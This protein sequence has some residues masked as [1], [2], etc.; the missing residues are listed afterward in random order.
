MNKKCAALLLAAAGISF[1]LSA[2]NDSI[3]VTTDGKI[4]KTSKI[5][6]NAKGDLEYLTPDGKLKNRIPNGRFR[7]AQVPK[8]AEITEA[9]Q[10]Y[11]KQQW[12][13]AAAMYHKAASDYRLLGWEVYC[14][15]MEA[16]SLAKSGEKAQ[17]EK[18]LTGL[19]GTG[20]NNPKQ[21]KERNLADNFLADL[22]IDRK[23][24]DAAEKILNRQL[25]QDDPELVFSAFV[26]KAE[27][28]QGRGRRKEALQLYYQAVLFFPGDPRRAEAL[29]NTW[30]L[31]QETKDPRAAKIA[32]MLKREYPNSPFAQKV[33]F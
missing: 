32:E 6:V 2:A 9:D 17:A 4:I 5:E 13:T 8:P 23:Q 10:N 20:E 24:F 12:K 25:V 11:R 26:K 31:M 30:N 1:T 27:I 22:L 21:L 7:Y 3:I 19:H 15:R 16:E 14:I 33:F 29:Y 18:L 28:M